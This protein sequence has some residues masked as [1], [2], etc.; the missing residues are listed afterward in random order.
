MNKIRAMVVALVVAMTVLPFF[1]TKA[2]AIVY[3]RRAYP[4]GGYYGRRVIVRQPAVVVRPYHRFYAHPYHRLYMTPHHFYR[5][6]F[7]R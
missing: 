3:M 6:G 2:D 1:A 5:H 4:Y 7:Y